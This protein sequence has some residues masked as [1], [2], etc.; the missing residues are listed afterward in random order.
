MYVAS[1]HV[2]ELSDPA[3]ACPWVPAGARFSQAGLTGA[4]R[5]GLP[6]G[7]GRWWSVLCRWD[8]HAAADAAQQDAGQWGDAWH[9]RLEP[10]AYRGDVRAADG[11]P[12]PF[13]DLPTSGRVTGPAAV[14]TWAGLGSDPDRLAEFLDRFG[15]LAADL[16]QADGAVASAVLTPTAGPVLTFSAWTSLRATMAWAYAGPVHTAAIARQEEVT[17]VPTAGFLRCAVVGSSGSLAGRDPLAALAL[18]ARSAA[19]VAA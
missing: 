9:V 14:V 5:A 6:D 19:A 15:D 12:A 13:D 3:R 18:P 7:S 17:L 1:W 8:D 4:G 16:A 10:V 11:G 2:L